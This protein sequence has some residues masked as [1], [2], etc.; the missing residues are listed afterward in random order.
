MLAERTREYFDFDSDSPYMLF[1]APVT[2]RRR[3]HGAP[4][5]AWGIDRLNQPRSDIPAVTHLDYSARL[6]TV[7]AARAPG[8]HEL[9]TAFDARTG[10]PV[11]VNTAFNVRGEPIVCSPADA[12][13]C[14]MR[15]DL[16]A[17][18]IPPFFLV[19]GEQ[20]ALDRSRWQTALIPD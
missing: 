9:L 8:L 7:S 13:A 10:C 6:Q 3:R 14:F 1:V 18:A 11:L 15:T 17:L 5:D 4:G 12:Y 16:D 2:A 19:K 20:P